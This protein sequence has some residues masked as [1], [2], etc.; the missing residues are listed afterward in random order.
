[1]GLHVDLRGVGY[2]AIVVCLVASQGEL[3]N[4]LVYLSIGL[5]TPSCRFSYAFFRAGKE[6]RDEESAIVY[7]E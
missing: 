7:R 1:M 4:F 2:L 6:T 5:L 3:L